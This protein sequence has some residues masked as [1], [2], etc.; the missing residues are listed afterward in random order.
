MVDDPE[1]DIPDFSDDQKLDEPL[2]ISK[3][4]NSRSLA[5]LWEGLV[6]IGLGEAA[7]RAGTALASIALVLMV[8]WVLSNF[9]LKGKVV[10]PQSAIA[11]AGQPTATA[12]IA[13]PPLLT[14]DPVKMVSG[15][16]RQALLH[17]T[18]PS[19]PRFDITQ[20]T[21][22]DGDTLFTIADRFDLLPQT[23]LWGNPDTLPDPHW[24]KPGQVLNILPTD[25]VL[26]T[27]HEG[28]GLNAVAEYYN[29]SPD[30]IVDWPGNH[31]DK[32][33][34]GDY[35]HPN[36]EPGTQLFVPGGTGN[37]TS[38]TMP[39]ITRQDPASAKTLGPGYCG[40]I[41]DGAYGTG[42]FVWPT[43]SH[44]ISGYH[45]QPEINHFGIDIG[46][47]VGM[48]IYASDS[49]VVVY[50]GWN[51]YGYG[52]LLVIDHGNGWQTYYAHL[53]TIYAQCGQSVYQGD[54]VA[55]MGLTGNTTG[56][57]LHFEMRSDT[58]GKVD[59]LLYLPPA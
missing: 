18:L 43:P 52:N 19:R 2:T 21:V 41:Y 24:L 51:D 26:Y 47:A 20:Y 32:N 23:L 16:T 34:V 50:S 8:I 35:S 22:Q 7:V 58:Y 1:L 49:G 29:V 9:Y 28:D 11:E 4:K 30:D 36:I 25:G 54:Q 42:S 14:P 40:E 48:A 56:P 5:D 33:T 59:P 37:F 3:K 55:L 44:Y 39:Q 15:I 46:G 53:E 12:E 45:Y 17:T 10:Q 27:W 31:L 13:N 6:R 38:W 57:H